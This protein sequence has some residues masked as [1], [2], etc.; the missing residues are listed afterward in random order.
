MSK[1]NTVHASILSALALTLCLLPAV[2]NAQKGPQGTTGAPLKSVD[3]KL[4]KNPGGSPAARTTTGPNGKFIFPV[5]PKGEY[6]MT[7][8]LPED[9][10][11]TAK[12]RSGLLVEFTDEPTKR[13]GYNNPGV[14]PNPSPVRFCYIILNL[15]GGRTIEKGFDLVKKKAFDPAIDPTKQSTSK[16]INLQDFI[17]GSDGE[18]PFSG[19]VVKSKSNITNN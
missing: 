15:R 2:V 17:V 5:V 12:S 16:T 10:K 4:G 18:T 9:P 8:S 13:G 7:V 1:R 6:I 19:A 11:N 3:V 14:S